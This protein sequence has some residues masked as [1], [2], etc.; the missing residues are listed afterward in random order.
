MSSTYV[1]N[2]AVVQISD[3]ADPFVL[4]FNET[5]ESNCFPQVPKFSTNF[6][7]RRSDAI[8]KVIASAYYCDGGMVRGT[9]G[10]SITPEFELGKWEEAFANPLAWCA[11]TVV[12]PTKRQY[13]KN[14][15][16]TAAALQEKIRDVCLTYQTQPK[17][18]EYEA[19]CALGSEFLLDLS[20]EASLLAS[21]ELTSGLFSTWELF[22]GD[23]V[24]LLKKAT[25]QKLPACEGSPQDYSLLRLKV[26]RSYN[27]QPW[28]EEMACIVQD[29][30]IVSNNAV[31]WLCNN[32]VHVDPKL[33]PISAARIEIAK[34]RRAVKALH[35]FSIDQVALTALPIEPEALGKLN[36]WQ[37]KEL[38]AIGLEDTELALGEASLYKA[39]QA[40]DMGLKIRVEGS[41]SE[42]KCA[43]F[44][45]Q[46]SLVFN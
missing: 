4:L 25:P 43:A 36:E 9:K 38:A 21:E 17:F 33:N 18:Y 16:A 46:E 44:A 27:D 3:H 14:D 1:S 39:L 40:T 6:F 45:S 5:C 20:E 22:S 10:K 29:G 31:H 7:G 12:V 28:F 42:S 34:Y 41:Q 37:T 24:H 15:E 23:Y 2:R 8:T 30:H 13:Q 19:G 35:A 11:K 26:D 32:I